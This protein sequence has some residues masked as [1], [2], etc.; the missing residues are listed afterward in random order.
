MQ[1]TQEEQWETHYAAYMAYKEEHGK[2]HSQQKVTHA[3]LVKAVSGK[4]YRT[5]QS[6]GDEFGVTRERIRQLLN[7]HGLANVPARQKPDLRNDCKFCNFPVNAKRY[8]ASGTIYPKTHDLCRKAYN[9]T[10]WVTIPC[11]NCQTNIRIRK[12]ERDQRLNIRKME[13]HIFCSHSCS[14]K[15]W[16][17]NSN[18]KI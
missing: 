17:A 10:L 9:S 4:E 15:Y 12:K 7:K 16:W 2:I 8:G 11:S 18:K 13:D 14:T 1:P 3:Q 6:I 5:L